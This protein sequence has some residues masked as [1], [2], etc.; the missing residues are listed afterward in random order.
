M[1]APRFRQERGRLAGAD[2]MRSQ[3]WQ[4]SQAVP[5]S[6]NVRAEGHARCVQLRAHAHHSRKHM[7]VSCCRVES[8]SN[9]DQSPLDFHETIAVSDEDPAVLDEAPT[10]HCANGEAL[11]PSSQRH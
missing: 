8:H 1:R 11:I 7:R 4:L 9:L 6:A 2:N 10:E 3:T 5:N